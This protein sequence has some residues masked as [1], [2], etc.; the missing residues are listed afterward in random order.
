MNP[1]LEAVIECIYEQHLLKKS[2]PDSKRFLFST[3]P[4]LPKQLL[5]DILKFIINEEPPEL[6]ESLMNYYY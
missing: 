3:F 6:M 1:I 4:N 2:I 5:I